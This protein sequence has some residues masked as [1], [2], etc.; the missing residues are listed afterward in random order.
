VVDCQFVLFT[1]VTQQIVAI[2]LYV[3]FIANKDAYCFTNNQP[4]SIH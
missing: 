4:Q 2:S 1:Q 3:R